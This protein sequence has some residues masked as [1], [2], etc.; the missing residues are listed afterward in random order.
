MIGVDEVAYEKGRKCLTVV[1]DVREDIVI[2]VGIG[3]K[4]LSLDLFYASL[5]KEKTKQIKAVVMDVW[6]LYIAST[7]KCG[8]TQKRSFLTSSTWPRWRA[9]ALTA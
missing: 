4:E 8:L 6:D 7:R 1:R 5:G 9:N 3:G 2:W